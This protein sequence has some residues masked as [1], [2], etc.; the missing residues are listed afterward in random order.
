MFFS[1]QKKEAN[2]KVAS[3]A[4]QKNINFPVNELMQIKNSRVDEKVYLQFG[5]LLQ[6]FS[7]S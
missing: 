6:N 3:F 2:I 1:V 4:L 7:F 5:L